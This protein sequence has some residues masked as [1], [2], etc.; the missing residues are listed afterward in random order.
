MPKNA[1]IIS[2]GVPNINSFLYINDQ[3]ALKYTV[4]SRNSLPSLSHQHV[5]DISNVWIYER[6]ISEIAFGYIRGLPYFLKYNQL[7][8]LCT[9]LQTQSHYKEVPRWDVFNRARH[10]WKCFLANKN[11]KAFFLKFHI[12]LIHQ[13][14]PHIIS[15]IIWV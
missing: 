4:M 11:F 3:F 2:K 10:N 6:K 1:N 8:F 13:N 7:T 14:V 9:T 5:F 15:M 12:L